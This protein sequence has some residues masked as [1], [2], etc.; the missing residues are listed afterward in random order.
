LTYGQQAREPSARWYYGPLPDLLLGGGLFY[1][2]IFV[3]MALFDVGLQTLAPIT[4]LPLVVLLTGVPHYGATVLRVCEHPEDRRAYSLVAI[5]SSAALAAALVVGLRSADFGSWLLT[6]YLTW[7]PWHYSGQNYGI[8]L[9]FLRRRGVPVSP[10]AKRF[11]YASFVLSF[12]LIALSIHGATPGSDYA[13]V[14]YDGT[15]YELRSLEVSDAIRGPGLIVLAVAYLVSLAAAG[16]LLL[17]GGSVRDLAPA[18]AVVASQ[19]LWFVAPALARYAGSFQVSGPLAAGSATY[20]FVWIGIAHSVQYLWVTSYFALRSE[21]SSILP[22]RAARRRFLA[23]YG[24]KVLAIGAALWI[25]PALLFAPGAL[26][27]LPYDAGLSVMIAAAVN[28][29]HFILDGAIWKLRDGR[30]ARILIRNTAQ[31]GE[32]EEARASPPGARRGLLFATTSV[33]IWSLGAI[34]AVIWVFGVLEFE[35]GTRAALAREDLPRT[36]RSV[37][38]LAWV[39]RDSAA[40]RVNVG[41]L[42]AREGDLRG[43]IEHLERSLSLHETQAALDGLGSLYSKSGRYPDA[44]AAYRRAL[45]LEPGD[46]EI[47][48][49]LAWT[50]AVHGS[51]DS[52]A[53]EEAISLANRA[54]RHFNNGNAATLDTLAVAHAAAGHFQQARR[55]GRRALELARERGD[56]Q[57]AGEI[58]QR[59]ALYRA[60][61]PFR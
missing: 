55:I 60:R 8:A 21:R 33:L 19:A 57:L 7:S 42:A 58:A 24:G 18:V 59:L 15:V 17:R 1:V 20:A 37:D 27:D 48:N 23:R 22:S 46:P 32:P 53:V 25:L 12:V 50:L 51:H 30:I 29:H 9:M 4:L 47:L 36:E 31:N 49:N 40:V 44:I 34:C 56:H 14:H 38:R 6:V 41:L 35:L 39:G 13:P 28:V 11:L 45:D 16:G 26:G 61:R 10:A 43:G 3:S 52:A 5:G 54:A 2:A